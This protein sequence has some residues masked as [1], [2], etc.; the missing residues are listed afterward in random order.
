MSQSAVSHCG[1]YIRR[2]SLFHSL[3]CPTVVLTTGEVLNDTVY[4]VPLWFLYQ[5]ELFIP[6]SAVYHCGSYIRRGP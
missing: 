5:E 2:S 6:Q 4:S 3:Q 1:S